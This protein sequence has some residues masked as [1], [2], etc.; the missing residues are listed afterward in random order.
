M[1]RVICGFIALSLLMPA[2]AQAQ[3]K[4]YQWQ[5]ETKGPV[6]GYSGWAGISNGR[7]NLYCD[8]IRVPN[9]E[10]VVLKS[11][12]ERCQVTSWTLEQTCE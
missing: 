6:H 8:Y 9:R 12:K 2:G 11:G 10:C 7:R 4:Y 3:G 1:V 5:Y